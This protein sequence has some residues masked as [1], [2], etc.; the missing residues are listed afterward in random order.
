MIPSTNPR[1]PPRA[2]FDASLLRV[3]RELRCELETQQPVNIAGKRRIQ[4]SLRGAPQG[5]PLSPLASNLYLNSLDHEVNGRPE[6]NA[7]LVRYADDFVLLCRPGKGAA[8]FARLKVYLER[9]GLRLNETKT[10][11]IDARQTSFRFLGFEVSG[12]RTDSASTTR[13]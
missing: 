10:R 13:L 7:R 4:P 8:M 3:L 2:V 11:V 9:R 6:T 1:N 12:G 5:G